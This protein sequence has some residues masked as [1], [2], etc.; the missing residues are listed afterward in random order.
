MMGTYL[1]DKG[2]LEDIIFWHDNEFIAILPQHRRFE[3]DCDLSSHAW[4]YVST[5]SRRILDFRNS[6]LGWL[7]RRKLDT[8]HHTGNVHQAHFEFIH[9]ILLVV[10][11]D[12]L[13][14]VT[15]QWSLS[16]VSSV[17]VRLTYRLQYL[18]AVDLWEFRKS[19]PFISRV[20]L[21]V[22]LSVDAG[23]YF[24][25]LDLLVHRQLRWFFSRQR[26]WGGGV[27][28]DLKCNFSC[29]FNSAES[30][31]PRARKTMLQPLARVT[32]FLNSETK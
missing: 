4:S 14:W 31:I 21:K 26:L 32:S 23:Q 30:E 3:P 11:E 10:T 16:N 13:R 7:D 5:L 18:F 6:E 1:A 29:S 20:L 12:N 19:L 27:V 17:D 15:S 22:N 24:L 25:V 8:L 9:S 2:Y 28:H